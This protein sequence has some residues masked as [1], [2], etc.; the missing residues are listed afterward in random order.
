MSAFNMVCLY[1]ILP[2]ITVLDN[3]NITFLL[4]QEGYF[5]EKRVGQSVLIF[6]IF[7]GL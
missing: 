1:R 6:A 7:T 3:K 5:M 2:A 4:V